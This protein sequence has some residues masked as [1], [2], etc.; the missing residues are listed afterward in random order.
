MAGRPGYGRTGHRPPAWRRPAR[1]GPDRPGPEWSPGWRGGRP[2][3]RPTCVGTG[4]CRANLR[5]SRALAPVPPD[6]GVVVGGR[7]GV[8]R[9]VPPFEGGPE[10]FAVAP[11]GE[12]GGAGRH[13][14]DG[15]VLGALQGGHPKAHDL[16]PPVGHVL[17]HGQ[18]V[19]GRERDP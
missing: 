12:L 9:S 6:P 8:E 1:G 2:R 15:V 16:V 11:P 19:E 17:V 18:R 4:G 7:P 14:E 5:W 13:V 3:G 10:A